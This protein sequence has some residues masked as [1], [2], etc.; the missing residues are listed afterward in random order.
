MKSSVTDIVKHKLIDNPALL[1][2]SKLMKSLIADVVRDK[3]FITQL[4]LVYDS[5]IIK[6][7]RDN[8]GERDS[9][10][11]SKLYSMMEE[12]TGYSFDIS[13]RVIDC[14]LSWINDDVARAYKNYLDLSEI[15]ESHGILEETHDVKETCESIPEGV[16]LIP[17]GVG[18]NDNGFL[19]LGINKKLKYTGVN[20]SIFAILYHYLQRN[21]HIDEING[22]P[23]FIKDKIEH[24][25]KYMPDYRIIYRLMMVILLMIRYN[26]IRESGLAFCFDG[27]PYDLS[28]AFDCI[29]DYLALFSR[30]AGLKKPIH[31]RHINSNEI[32]VSLKDKMADVFVC[33][34]NGYSEKTRDIWFAQNVIYR[35]NEEH[36]PFLEILLSEISPYRT[37]RVGQYEALCQMLNIQAHSMCIMPTGSGKS[38]IFYLSAILQPGVTIVISPTSILI[39][40]QIINLSETHKFDDIAVLCEDN[41]KSFVNYRL[42][43]RIIYITPDTFQNRDLLKEFIYW[44]D[45]MRIS[46]IVLDEVHC[47]SNWSHD[48]RPEYLMLSKYLNQYLDRVYFKGY[49]ATANYSVMLDLENQLGIMDE[50]IISP[51]ELS[52]NDIHFSF[53]PCESY[54]HMVKTLSDKLNK[55]VKLGRKA[56]VFTK[57]DDMSKILAEALPEDIRYNADVYCSDD[58]SAYRRFAREECLSHI[59]IASDELGVGIN[60]SDINDVLHFGLPLSKAEFVQQ[61]GR[62]GRNG[63]RTTSTVIYLACSSKNVNETLLHRSSTTAKIAEVL[64]DE[65][66]QNDYL[67]VY[68]KLL[69]D[70]SNREEFEKM[71][72]GVFSQVQGENGFLELSYNQEIFSKIKKCYYALFV[73]G[74]VKNWSVCDKNIIGVSIESENKNMHKVKDTFTKYLQHVGN[75]R[76]SIYIVGRAKSENE[77]ISAYLDWYY[78]YFNYYH[79]EQFLD[80]LN[81]FETYKQGRDNSNRVIAER[82]ASYFSLQMMEVQK[83]KNKYTTL[84]YKDITVNVMQEVNSRTQNNIE[85]LN[86]NN[87]HV[88][89]D[90]YLF[91]FELIHAEVFDLE[92]L[93]RITANTGENDILDFIEAASLLYE[94]AN[95]NDR[96]V[97]FE[98]LERVASSHGVEFKILFDT[99][100]RSNKRDIVYYGMIIKRLNRTIKGV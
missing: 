90:W 38:L 45:A 91:A 78:E 11:A 75:Y 66:Q 89:F 57:N 12:Y 98:V 48:F 27:S 25:L 93:E 60:L 97:L 59:L 61:I 74:L 69:G 9:F 51:V 71:I 28:L 88:K 36:R 20:D 26:Y 14:W 3:A 37:F 21:N 8:T 23:R 15:K 42:V 4:L 22:L 56:L 99:I 24:E 64:S 7:I 84:S 18:K 68:R 92:R 16:V 35:L 63:G 79:R 77:L 53:M 76:K 87:Y 70:T 55:T 65:V 95:I 1:S 62:A 82:L 13:K 34:Y 52:K 85:R 80:M 32:R 86:Q 2:S 49:T 5:D 31:I 67:D 47:I 81:F 17:C 41:E 40:D 39:E 33:D 54:T 46:I 43:N 50:H 6:L 96:I 44:N 72:F 19:V 29:N 73:M 83:D 30:I 94:K 100:F 10:F 58:P